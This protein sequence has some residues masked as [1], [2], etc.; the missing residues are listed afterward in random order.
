MKDDL[1][2]TITV[3]DAGREYFGL[4]RNAAYAAAQ[5]GDIPTIKIGKLLRVPV[6]ALEAMLNVKKTE[7]A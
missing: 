2:K 7:A 3:P 4:S 6:I 1:P 5:R